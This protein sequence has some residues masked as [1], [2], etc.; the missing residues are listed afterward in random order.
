MWGAW[1]MDKGIKWTVYSLGPSAGLYTNAGVTLLHNY[2]M[3]MTRQD[4]PMGWLT[5]D[6][7]GELWA[8]GVCTARIRGRLR[9]VNYGYS[10]GVDMGYGVGDWVARE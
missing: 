8:R 7:R 1:C 6:R 3:E 9:V 10:R 5:T 4:G 2:R